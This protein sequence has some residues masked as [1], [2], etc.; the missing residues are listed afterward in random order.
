[1][2]VLGGNGKASKISGTAKTNI[3][4]HSLKVNLTVKRILHSVS[5]CIFVL[6][7]VKT[8]FSI[9]HS[10]SKALLGL[11]LVW[12]QREPQLL[13]RSSLQIISSQHLIR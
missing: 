4:Y 10:V 11:V 6:L 8:E 7:Q 2:G 12:Q 5:Y 13:L 3:T 9:P 1:M